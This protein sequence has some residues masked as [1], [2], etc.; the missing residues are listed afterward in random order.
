MS[1]IVH[2]PITYVKYKNGDYGEYIHY[3]SYPLENPGIILTHD[4][5]KCI[6]RDED[7]VY[8]QLFTIDRRKYTTINDFDIIEVYKF[9]VVPCIKLIHKSSGKIIYKDY[10]ESIEDNITKSKKILDMVN[11]TKDVIFSE[12]LPNSIYKN[13]MLAYD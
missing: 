12:G 3:K 2:R 13:Y 11:K 10:D 4:K 1:N 7:A 6:S 8:G 9:T 5:L